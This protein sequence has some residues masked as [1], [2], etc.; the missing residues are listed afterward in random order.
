MT[1]AGYFV[2][3]ESCETNIP[4]VFV[5]GDCRTKPL[6]QIATAI[7]DGAIAGNKSADFICYS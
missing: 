4:G 3:D 6:R 5:A 1:K 2:S 7:A